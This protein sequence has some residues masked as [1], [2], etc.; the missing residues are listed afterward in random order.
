MII[1]KIHCN[2]QGVSFDHIELNFYINGKKG[3]IAFSNVRGT[4]FPALFG[5]NL[6]FKLNEY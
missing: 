2:F 5:M 1:I 6:I 3:N 4:V